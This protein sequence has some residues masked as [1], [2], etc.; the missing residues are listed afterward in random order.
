MANLFTLNMFVAKANVIHNNFYDYSLVQYINSYTKIKII[1]PKH[2]EFE[3]KPNGHLNGRG[4]R[5]CGIEKQKN[6]MR[7]SINDFIKKAMFIHNNIYDY[8]LVNFKNTHD[9]IKIICSKHGEFLQQ[10]YVHLDG[11]GCPRCGELLAG[12]KNRNNCDNFITKAKE[13]H[14]NKYDYSNVNYITANNYVDIMCLIHGNFSQKPN[15]H[16]NGTGC[17]KC[18]QSR[19]EE[20]IMRFLKE[21]KINF[22]Y[23]KSFDDC[24][25]KDKLFFDF[26]LPNQNILI[27][28]DGEQHFYP[29]NHF[30]G[31]NRLKKQIINDKIKNNFA[32]SNNYSLLRIKFDQ[33]NEIDKILE[34]YEPI[35]QR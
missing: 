27:E 17:P 28:Y 14:G 1:C 6:K 8:K 12:M 22:E 32:E 26:Y 33:I 30:G 23:Q 11:S 21:N 15:S 25:N 7:L 31:L 20:K 2:G 18:K 35:S 34:I 5:F 13:I 9:Y 4:C 10:A 24:R 3:Q 19:G 16:L 29:I